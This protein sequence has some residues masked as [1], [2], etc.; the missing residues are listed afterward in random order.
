MQR[1]RRDHR[2]Y[3]EFAM[4][5]QVTEEFTISGMTCGHCVQAVTQE[6]TALEGVESV[7]V[8]LERGTASVTSQGPLGLDE[9]AAAVD[10]AGF[11]LVP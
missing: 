9:V 1:P 5:E 3:E 11:E 6:L 7:R 4:S 2:Q 8:D 10:E